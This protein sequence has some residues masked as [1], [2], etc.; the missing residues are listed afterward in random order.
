MPGKFLVASS[1]NYT[2]RAIDIALKD[3][4]HTPIIASDGLEV[5]DLTLDQKPNAVFIGVD[6][7]GL[8]GLDVARALRALDPTEHMPIIFLAENAAFATANRVGKVQADQPA[9]KFVF[10][11]W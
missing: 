2:V 6:L 7:P 1:N 10:H 5:V 3:E 8:E 4:K 9:W 11:I